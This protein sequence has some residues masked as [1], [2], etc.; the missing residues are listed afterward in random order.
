MNTESFDFII[1]GGGTAGI[2]L[3]SRLSEVAHQT[4]LVLEAGVDHSDDPRVKT[5]AFYLALFGTDVD[6]GFRTVAQPNLNGRSLSLN[7]GKS[8]GGSSVMNVQVYAPPTKAIPDAWAEL[9]N[10]GWD[11]D[12]MGPYYTKAFTLPQTPRELRRHLGIDNSRPDDMNTSG[13]VQLS[14]P[15]DPSHPIRKIW[16]ETFERKGYLMASD[17]WVEA[18]VGAFSNLANI[19]PIR[20][21][22]CHAAKAYYSPVQDRQ[23][24]QILLDAHV[25][26]I[27]FADGQPQPKAIGVQYHHEGKMKIVNARKEIIICTGALQSPKLLELSGIGNTDILKQHNIEV[28]KDLPGVGENL[29][30]H[31]VC[32][33]SFAAVDEMDTLDALARQEPKA[34]EQAMLSFTQNHNGPLTS[35][36]I[37]TY[38]YLPIIDFLE[39]SGREQL[40][41]LIDENRPAVLPTPSNA[42]TQ[43][44]Y[45][46]AEKMLLDPNKPS[47]VYLTAIGQNTIA[48]DPATGKPAPPQ[49]GNH[50]TIATVLAQPLS[51]GIVHIVSN[52]SNEAPEI[53]PKYLSNPLDMEVLAQHVMYIRSIASSAPLSDVLKQ[54]LQPS[55]PLAHITDLDTAKR[56]IESR[57]ISMWHPAGTCAMLPEQIG[58]V[59]DASLRVHG[60]SNLRVVD[61]SVVPL[62]PPGNLQSTIYAVAER[63]A[64]LIKD[65]YNMN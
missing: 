32:D 47:G 2:A 17:P 27:L 21:E 22:R 38:A 62:L 4:V 3:A 25:D 45:E 60:V 36:G 26:K 34:V 9:G 41:R 24:L 39:G 54:P 15:G 40:V 18:S 65:A 6:W 33:I 10:V 20:R 8:L 13:P 30:D 1:A 55:S 42:K 37:K 28:I 50:F 23:N 61:S 46:I 52:D 11:W 35:A 53:D 49:P 51:R 7:Q 58:G 16:A 64:D 63:A 12:T 31:L 29:Q 44:Y 43:K 19:D 56:Y 57:T 48:A 14:Y 59:V 5:P